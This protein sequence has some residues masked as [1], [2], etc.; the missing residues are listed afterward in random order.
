MG[1]VDL[2]MVEMRCNH[3][4]EGSNHGG[5]EAY[6]LWRVGLTMVERG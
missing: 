2:T 4:G 6:P 1:R 5:E 3:G